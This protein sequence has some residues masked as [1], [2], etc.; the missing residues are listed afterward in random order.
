MGRE[1]VRSRCPRSAA[2][3]KLTVLFA[4][5]RRRSTMWPRKIT[6]SQYSNAPSR[7]PTYVADSA[8][9]DAHT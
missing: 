5:V 4:A 8:I 1:I 7:P 3:P 6:P 9:F 2:T